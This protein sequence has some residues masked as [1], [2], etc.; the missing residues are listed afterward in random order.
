MSGETMGIVLL[1][2]VT[3]PCSHARCLFAIFRVCVCVLSSTKTSFRHSIWQYGMPKEAE[4]ARRHERKTAGSPLTRGCPFLRFVGPRTTV[5]GYCMDY[6][7]FLFGQSLVFFCSQSFRL[8]PVFDSICYSWLICRRCSMALQGCRCHVVA[9]LFFFVM[10]CLGTAKFKDK[11]HQDWCW[12]ATRV[13][14]ER[15]GRFR[16]S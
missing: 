12:L 9:C 8:V 2:A 7:F 14:W 6:D 10:R 16:V 4:Q 13:R 1:L 3:R 11:I 15:R 5:N